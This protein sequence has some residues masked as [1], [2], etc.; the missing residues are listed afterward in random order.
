MIFHMKISLLIALSFL[1]KT[2]ISAQTTTFTY[3]A[4]GNQITRVRPAVSYLVNISPDTAILEGATVEL[5]ATGGDEY[6]WSTGDTTASIT[7]Q[8]DTTTHYGIWVHC[9][10]GAIIID[11]ITVEVEQIVLDASEK[12]KTVLFEVF[13]NPVSRDMFQVSIDLPERADADL[14]LT[15]SKGSL[16]WRRHIPNAGTVRMFEPVGNLPSG[17]YQLLLRHGKYSDTR[18]IVIVK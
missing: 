15:D 17:H 16:I 3:D 8:P 11:T 4:N 9:T 7:V 2:S 14:Q 12:D 5:I 13:P 6:L 18:Q 10:C 1:L